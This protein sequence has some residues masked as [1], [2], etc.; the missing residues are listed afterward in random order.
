[1]CM[2]KTSKNYYLNLII[3]EEVNDFLKE[4]AL[5]S[6]RSKRKEVLQ[7]IKNVMESERFK[8]VI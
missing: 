3:T 2:K 4:R 5:Q 1:M 7:L 6:G 8:S